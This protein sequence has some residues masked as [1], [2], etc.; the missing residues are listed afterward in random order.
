MQHKVFGQRDRLDAAVRRRAIRR[1]YLNAI[2]WALGNG[3]ASTTLVVYLALE[4][5][6]AGLG[7]SLLLAAPA[8][9]GAPVG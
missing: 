9:V 2:L 5:G 1:S 8:L 7:I 4:L 6:A 3:L